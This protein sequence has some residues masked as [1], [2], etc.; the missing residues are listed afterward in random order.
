MKEEKVHLEIQ[1]T[2][3]SPVGVIRSTYWDS[4]EKKIK[5][6]NYGRIKGK[7]LA[8]L[9]NIQS[10]MRDGGFSSE[11]IEI[12][13][14]QE[15]GATA[16]FRLIIEQL[17]LDRAIYSRKEQWVED[18]IAMISGNLAYGCSKL[19]LCNLHEVS[20]VWKQAG[21]FSRPDVRKHCY[22]SMDRLFDRQ[23][24]IQKS[25]LKRHQESSLV[26]YD[27]TSSYFEGEYK[28]SQMVNFGYN[29]DGKKG[30]KQ[31]VIGLVCNKQGCPL[32]VE[33]FPGKTKD[34]TTVAEKIKELQKTYGMKKVI[35]VGDRGML[36]ETLLQEY[37]KSDSID[38]ITAL[39]HHQMQ[40]LMNTEVLNLELFDQQHI[41]E[42]RDPNNPRIR[43]C[44]CYNPLRKQENES[45]RKSLMK[46]T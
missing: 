20:S 13:H 3:K 35:F 16:A 5:H 33:I 12:I 36:T 28:D 10:A 9:K 30:K 21:V 6:R 37:D 42:I 27:I 23:K 38:T 8:Q 32:A 22:K 29:R 7:T 1:N 18:V 2:R 15:F 34:E 24:A 31:V 26:L 45:T 19:G 4:V 17:G 25:L 44:V 46:L 14:S 39:T 43:Y 41:H 11:K 40:E